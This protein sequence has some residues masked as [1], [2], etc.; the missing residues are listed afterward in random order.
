MYDKEFE[1]TAM[2]ALTNFLIPFPYKVAK[3]LD[4]EIY[5]NIE[6][7][8]WTNERRVAAQNRGSGAGRGGIGTSSTAIAQVG[9]GGGDGGGGGQAQ[10][11]VNL[12][13]GENSIVAVVVQMSR[14]DFFIS[15]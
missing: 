9:G 3:A 4:P 2:E 11:I 8:V 6:Y 10:T 15:N 1:G 14:L 5:R 13:Y 12:S 7:D